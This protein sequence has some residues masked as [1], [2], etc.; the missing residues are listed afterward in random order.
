[1]S[2]ID[3]KSVIDEYGLDRVEISKLLFP[4]NRHQDR[5]LRRIEQSKA[6]LDADQISRLALFIGVSPSDLYTGGDW[7][8]RTEKGV[9]LFTNG[10][11]KAVLDPNTWVTKI[12]HNDS[13]FHES[14][15][16][17]GSTTLSEYLNT[18]D[19]L[20]HKYK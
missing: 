11:Y 10:D 18:I 2:V 7:K 17:S 5:A 14:V 3:L 1:M 4:A 16:H 15:I 20:I 12:F 13:M 9:H 19:S 8:Q 6:L